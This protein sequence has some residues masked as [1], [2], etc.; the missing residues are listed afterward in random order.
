[1]ISLPDFVRAVSAYSEGKVATVDTWLWSD[2]GIFGDDWNDFMV[3]TLDALG[4]D[5]DADFDVYN[6]IPLDDEVGLFGR[7]VAR[8][9]IPDL[10]LRELFAYLEFK[11]RH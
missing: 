2:L 10:R 9:T 8:R 5:A 4:V 11:T 6:Y 7:L 3:N 1:M